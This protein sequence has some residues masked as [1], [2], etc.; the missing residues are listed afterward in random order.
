MYLADYFLFYLITKKPIKFSRHN[1]I[2]NMGYGAFDGYVVAAARVVG[3]HPACNHVPVICSNYIVLFPSVF[4]WGTR[5]CP[6]RLETSKY[7]NLLNYRI[8]NEKRT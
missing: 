1:K 6:S 3:W 7:N 2:D 8:R 4:T 5:I